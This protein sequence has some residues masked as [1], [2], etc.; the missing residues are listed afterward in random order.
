M[1]FRKDQDEGPSEE[2]QERFGDDRVST[3]LCPDCGG[4]VFDDAEVCPRCFA[5]IDGGV[6]PKPRGR[7]GFFHRQW[8]TLLLVALVASM[9]SGSI[10]VLF[11]LMRR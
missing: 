3:G 1:P 7:R 9:L 11:Q 5:Y 2:D 8:K 6:R 4:E 10:F